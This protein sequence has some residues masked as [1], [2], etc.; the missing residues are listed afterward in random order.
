[1][2]LEL[3]PLYFLF[4][5]ANFVFFSRS[6][7]STKATVMRRVSMDFAIKRKYDRNSSISTLKFLCDTAKNDFDSALAC[8]LSLYRKG[9]EKRLKYKSRVEK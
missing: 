1:M 6:S 3:W 5:H 8:G 4:N 7:L 9:E 2:Y